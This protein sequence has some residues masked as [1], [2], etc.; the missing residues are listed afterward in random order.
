MM[1]GKALV[2]DL[3]NMISIL[4]QPAR[5]YRMQGCFSGQIPQQLPISGAQLLLIGLYSSGGL[6]GLANLIAADGI[7][8]MQLLHKVNIQLLISSPVDNVLL[9]MYR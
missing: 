8:L 6:Q 3:F 5:Y 7:L 4:L 9:R 2:D 1:P